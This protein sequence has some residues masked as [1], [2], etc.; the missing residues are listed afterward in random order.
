LELARVDDLGAAVD[1]L[2]LVAGGGVGEFVGG[3]EAELVEIAGLALVIEAV[4]VAAGIDNEWNRAGR[5]VRGPDYGVDGGRVRGPDAVANAFANEIGALRQEVLLHA[6][7][8]GGAGELRA[9][10]RIYEDGRQKIV[11]ADSSLEEIGRR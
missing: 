4:K 2:R 9:W 3:V 11:R 5:I 8:S 7:I 10:G 1:A 6:G